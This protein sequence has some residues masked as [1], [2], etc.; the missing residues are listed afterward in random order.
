MPD[1]RGV[2]AT[3]LPQQQD[4][5]SVA[6]WRSVL[7]AAL[8]DANNTNDFRY[9]KTKDAKLVAAY[10][11]IDYDYLVSKLDAYAARS[12]GTDDGVVGIPAEELNTPYHQLLNLARAASTRVPPIQTYS[13]FRHFSKAQ[14]FQINFYQYRREAFINDLTLNEEDAILAWVKKLD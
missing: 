12:R 9:F 8:E 5:A 14:D 13:A 6:L 11:E 1:V 3:P 2:H 10:A 4:R 7:L